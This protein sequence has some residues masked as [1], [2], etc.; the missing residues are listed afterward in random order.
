M[1]DN[2]CQ[3]VAYLRGS[4]FG[5]PQLKG[6]LLHHGFFALLRYGALARW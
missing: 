5:V 4:L 3:V 1:S 2:R 6:A